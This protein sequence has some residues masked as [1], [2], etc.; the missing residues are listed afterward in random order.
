MEWTNPW[1]FFLQLEY[2]NITRTS[3]PWNCYRHS[4]FKFW[5]GLAVW[6]QTL[7]GLHVDNS[8]GCKW[9]NYGKP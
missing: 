9:F 4:R 2:G 7:N 5:N 1:D 6:V 8:C 3:L